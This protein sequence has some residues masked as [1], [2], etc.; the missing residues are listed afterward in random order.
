MTGVV[1]TQPSRAESR[2]L[3]WIAIP[4]LALAFCLTVVSAY[5]PVILETFTDSGLAIGAL[6]AGEGLAA[7]LVPVLV[8]T[9]SDGLHTRLGP[10]L[11]ILIAATPIAVGGLVL[12]AFGSSLAVL[13]VALFLFYAAYFAYFGPYLALYPDLIREEVQGRAQGANGVARQLGLGLGLVAGGALLAASQSLPFIAAAALLALAAI[14]L[15]ARLRTLAHRREARAM[16]EGRILA[17]ALELLRRRPEI[18]GV[19]VVNALWEM[20]VAALKTFG[21]LFAIVGLGLAPEQVP[22]SVGLIAVGVVAGALIA[23]RLAD[24]YGAYR[25]LRITVW[26]YGVGLLMPFL[27]QSSGVLVVAMPLVAFGAGAVTT[28]A[29][30]ALVRAAPREAHGAASG[31]FALSRGIG[32]LLGPLLAGIAV[33]ALQPVLLST[34]GYAAAW[35]VAALAVLATVPVL[36]RLC[37]SEPAGALAG[38]LQTSGR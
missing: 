1:A 23:G 12:V 35:L 14:A 8:S 32:V 31:L 27:S 26:P 34:Q 16:S 24:R 20:S 29:Y 4:S 3:V 9:W 17:R 33:E 11:P 30:V 5:V 37:R 2:L 25:L 22:L 19:V 15:V 10:R 13:V 36:G 28:L 21:I 7:L 18:R 6:I 38:A